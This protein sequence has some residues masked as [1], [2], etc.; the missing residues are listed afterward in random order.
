MVCVLVHMYANDWCWLRISEIQALSYYAK[1]KKFFSSETSIIKYKIRKSLLKKKYISS[2]SDSDK[3]AGVGRFW[4]VFLEYSKSVPMSRFIHS[5]LRLCNFILHRIKLLTPLKHWQL[6]SP[7]SPYWLHF[8]IF[9]TLRRIYCFTMFR[10][11][12]W[13]HFPTQHTCI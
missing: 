10:M 7:M 4:S 1:K 8:H 6:H 13:L 5:K 3:C 9:V 2:T 12:C 11:H